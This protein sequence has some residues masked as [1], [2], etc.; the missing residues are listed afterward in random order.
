M[1]TTFLICLLL[2]ACSQKFSDISSTVNA[3][4]NSL[5]DVTLSDDELKKLPY[6]SAYVS[7][8]GN[9][10][11]LMVLALIEENNL[12]NYQRL[13]W[14]SADNFMIITEN[15]RIV[16]T[17]GFSNNLMVITSENSLNLPAPS[18]QSNKWIAYYD[19]MPS[20]RYQFTAEINS[21]LNKQQTIGLS[22]WSLDT[23]HVEEKI[24]F[25][26]LKFN[27]TNHYWLNQNGKVV[28]T[29]QYI[30]PNMDKIEMSFVKDFLP[31]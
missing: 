12:N 26:E 10:R 7:L 31:Q 19:W 17:L 30:G 9:R 3:S 25:S 27:F 29:I 4:V 2:S 1:T 15:G 16:K 13:K 14:V 5:T 20:H 6:D 11:I 8:N 18:I 21:S 24:N 22:S 23:Q 28:K